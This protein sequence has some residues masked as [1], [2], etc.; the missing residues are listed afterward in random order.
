M[1]V[2]GKKRCN[3]CET[4]KPLTEFCRNRASKDGLNF[5]CNVCNRRVVLEWQK[6]NPEKHLAKSRKWSATNRERVCA[7]N[8][9]YCKRNPKSN[10]RASLRYQRKHPEQRRAYKVVGKAI[11]RGNLTP[12]PCEVCASTQNI[13]AHHSR[14]D[15]PLDVRWLCT[16]CHNKLHIGEIVLPERDEAA[17]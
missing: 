15:R 10:L 1:L 4:V 2:D 5:R 6:N 11:K 8:R 3:W 13:E 14:Y 9:I 17:A 7:R 12:Q 16:R